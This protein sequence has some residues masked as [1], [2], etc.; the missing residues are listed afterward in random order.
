MI[1]KN[2]SHLLQKDT[3]YS[4]I[5]HERAELSPCVCQGKR[6]GRVGTMVF[7]GQVDIV[8]RFLEWNSKNEHEPNMF[9]FLAKSNFPIF[10]EVC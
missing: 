3:L 1:N 9:D 2:S 10:N 4:S 7:Q 5:Q 6:D 8:F